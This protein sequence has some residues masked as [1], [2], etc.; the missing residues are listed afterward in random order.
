MAGV[1]GASYGL[2]SRLARQQYRALAAMRWTM[3]RNGLRSFKGAAELGARIFVTTLFS[4]FGV[5]MTPSVS[6]FLVSMSMPAMNAESGSLGNHG[7]PG[8]GATFGGAVS[9]HCR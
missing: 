1:E 5:R 2:L 3:F 8:G 6:I 9:A 4:V 7:M